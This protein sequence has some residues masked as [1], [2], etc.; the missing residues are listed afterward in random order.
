MV[1]GNVCS[2]LTALPGQAGRIH[3]RPPYCSLPFT[4]LPEPIL[5]SCRAAAPQ[6]AA[7][8]P[9]LPQSSASLLAPELTAS[10]PLE[11]TAAV[12][13]REGRKKFF[14]DSSKG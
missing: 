9:L 8:V 4:A 2:G 10:A 1:H 5:C 3:Q 14:G 7:P 12:T 13:R 11:L 6:A